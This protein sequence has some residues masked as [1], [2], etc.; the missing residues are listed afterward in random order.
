MSAGYK[1]VRRLSYSKPCSSSKE[2]SLRLPIAGDTGI[3]DIGKFLLTPILGSKALY[4][5]R[6]RL[7]LEDKLIIVATYLIEGY[8]YVL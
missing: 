5:G 2:Q 8:Q 6:N 1:T 4:K 7:S 3:M